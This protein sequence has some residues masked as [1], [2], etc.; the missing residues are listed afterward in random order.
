MAEVSFGDGQVTLSGNVSAAT[1][2]P[3]WKLFLSQ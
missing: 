1:K 2:R 3:G